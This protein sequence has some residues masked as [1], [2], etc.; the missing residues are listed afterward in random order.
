MWNIPGVSYKTSTIAS[1]EFQIS[2]GISPRVSFEK[3][4]WIPYKIA[5]RILLEITPGILPENLPLV[6]SEKIP[7]VLPSYFPSILL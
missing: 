3:L 2:P 1:E 6:A 5:L 7:E 4:S